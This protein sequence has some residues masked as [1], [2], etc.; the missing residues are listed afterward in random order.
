MTDTVE[1]IEVLELGSGCGLVGLGL[2]QLVKARVLLTDLPDASEIAELNLRSTALPAGSVAS[3]E[4]L[5]WEHEALPQVVQA[6]MFDVVLVADCTYNSTSIPALVRTLQ[7]VVWRS[8]SAVVVVGMKVRHASELV[9]FDLMEAAE[10][11]QTGHVAI[12]LPDGED[13]DV[14]DTTNIDLYTFRGRGRLVE[15]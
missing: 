7:H 2:A 13:L 5:N 12:P 8:G 6:R 14:D 11:T 10:F 3:F 4:V 15:D 1:P 9:F